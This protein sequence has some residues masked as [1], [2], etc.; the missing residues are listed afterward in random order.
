MIQRDLVDYSLYL[1]TD[2]PLCGSRSLEDVVGQAVRAGATI[3]QL[4]E[5]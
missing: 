4:R 2:R 1:V 5:K 3:V